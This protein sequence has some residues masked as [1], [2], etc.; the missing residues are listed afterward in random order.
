MPSFCRQARSEANRLARADGSVVVLALFAAE[1]LALE[2]LE[3][4]H[5]AR[6]TAAAAIARPARSSCNRARVRRRV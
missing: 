5:A 2:L 6:V 4:P 3:P 1:V